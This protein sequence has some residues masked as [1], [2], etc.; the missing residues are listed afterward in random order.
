MKLELIQHA[1]PAIFIHLIFALCAF[2]V[3]AYQLISRKGT[4][5]HRI[6]GQIWVVM[7]FVIAVS[8]FWIR[9]VWPDSIFW[10]FSPIHL[11]SIFVMM[12]VSRGLYFARNG[13]I[14]KH[15]RAM[16]YTYVGGLII[17]GLF[18]L[19]PGRLLYQVFWS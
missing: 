9:S 7:M 17:A 12:Q 13:E 4:C 8:S 10:G 5:R 1:T 19:A 11:L 2:A 18:T 6:L 3:G 14:A 16:T 15:R